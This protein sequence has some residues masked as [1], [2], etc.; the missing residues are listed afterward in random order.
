MIKSQKYLLTKDRKI[1]IE[2]TVWKE[3]YI[4][5]VIECRLNNGTIRRAHRYFS[6]TLCK[7]LTEDNFLYKI[8]SSIEVMRYCAKL[9][10][11]S[12]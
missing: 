2:I 9:P 4:T 1:G 8:I 7:H 5:V 11:S 12:V 10:L 6:K 3:E